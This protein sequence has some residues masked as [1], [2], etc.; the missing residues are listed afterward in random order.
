VKLRYET[1]TATLIHFLVMMLFAFANGIVSIVNECRGSD[2]INCVQSSGISLIFVLVTAGWFGFLAMLGF[3]AQDQRS[4]RL[5][6]LLMAAEFMVLVVALF[7][8]KHF[9][10]GSNTILELLTSILDAS[11]AAWIILLAF[12]L[13]RAK[14][15]R[16]TA[17]RSPQSRPRRRVTPTA[18]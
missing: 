8:I 15:G 1:G 5:A 2:A 16:I 17:H 10:S 11:F 12:R 6:K 4:H 9:H 7:D 3:A 14:G 13:S 18:K